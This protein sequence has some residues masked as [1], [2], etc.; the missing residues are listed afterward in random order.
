MDGRGLGALFLLAVWPSRQSADLLN[1]VHNQELANGV[2]G[3]RVPET[4]WPVFL[5]AHLS[6]DAVLSLR[7]PG[8]LIEV[9]IEMLARGEKD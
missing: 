3:F 6:Q 4:A 9:G 8:Q 1:R 2:V 5:A 7:P